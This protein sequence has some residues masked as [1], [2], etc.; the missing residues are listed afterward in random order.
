MRCADVITNV[1]S[2]SNGK[3]D[4]CTGREILAHLRNCKYC[5]TDSEN[6]LKNE[7]GNANDSDISSQIMR[8]VQSL[9]IEFKPI[10]MP[11]RIFSLIEVKPVW[12]GCADEL[13][14]T[15][16]EFVEDPK[17]FVISLF[18]GDVLQIDQ[19]E[20][21]RVGITRVVL[22][23]FFTGL[24][25]VSLYYTGHGHGIGMGG[26]LEKIADLTPLV[27]PKWLKLPYP[28]KPAGNRVRSRLKQIPPNTKA[29]PVTAV[30]QPPPNTKARPVTAAL[31]PPHPP[32]LIQLPGIEQPAVQ[33]LPERPLISATNTNSLESEPKYHQTNQEVYRQVG[34][35]PPR[36]IAPGSLAK[37]VGNFDIQAPTAFQ[38]SPAP[39]QE[40][41][42]PA[43]VL[44]RVINP[45]IRVG[46]SGLISVIITSNN[47]SLMGADLLLR[48]DP[49]V[50][51]IT[52]MRDGGLLSLLGAQ[53]EFT[54]TEFEDFVRITIKRPYG[55]RPVPAIGQLVLIYFQ[56]TGEGTVELNLNNSELH[57]PDGKSVPLSISNATITVSP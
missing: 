14:D 10:A 1:K 41:L 36:I 42:N 35:D 16:R 56:G 30:L 28:G 39:Q 47:V 21:W 31:N 25:S 34:T 54:H 23:W 8:K 22:V 37:Q 51:K 15:F 53:A 2:L 9:I 5:R 3:I 48:Y 24:F 13:R 29:R 40:T 43:K 19:S 18:R 55:A 32:I 27:A 50:I 17:K 7:A 44:I 57:S 4:D 49:D 45:K 46:Q 6:I 26:R 11:E 52:S 20:Y 33:P 12:A 38:S